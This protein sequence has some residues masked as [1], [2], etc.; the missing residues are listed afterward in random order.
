M[1][2]PGF[3]VKSTPR[4]SCLVLKAM[5]ME[6]IEKQGLA[7]QWL[8]ITMVNIHLLYAVGEKIIESMP[9]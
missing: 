4:S 5:T 6:M 9:A 1:S 2:V 3:L 7:N 8:T